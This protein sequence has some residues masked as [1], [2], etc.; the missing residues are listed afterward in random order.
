MWAAS[1]PYMLPL[2]TAKQH[3]RSHSAAWTSHEYPLIVCSNLSSTLPACD[4]QGISYALP[5]WQ[6]LHNHI[7]IHFLKMTVKKEYIWTAP[8]LLHFWAEC[9]CNRKGILLFWPEGCDRRVLT[10]NTLSCRSQ[11]VQRVHVTTPQLNQTQVHATTWD[12]K[13][14]SSV[15]TQA[16]PSLLPSAGSIFDLMSLHYFLLDCGVLKIHTTNIMNSS[17]ARKIWQIEK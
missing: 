6:W 13:E 17:N 8:S 1:A 4:C 3:G 7:P 12:D 11:Q 14:S 16:C 15:Q 5:S 9:M 10:D 2:G